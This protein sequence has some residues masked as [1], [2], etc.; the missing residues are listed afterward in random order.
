MV[1]TK[2]RIGTIGT[3][4]RVLVGL[5][6]LFLALWDGGL[7]FGLRW[8]DV[9]V[10]L[11]VLPGAMVGVGLAARRLGRGPLRFTGPVGLALNTAI[12]VALAA[13]EYTGA[14]A[15]LFYG[16]TLLVAAWRAQPG[17]EGLVL[18]NWIL[19]RDHQGGCP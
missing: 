11:V 9:A 6:L 5:G 4:S 8:Y 10:G 19:P 1:E 18:S 7:S 15:A 16:T 2:R 12:I 14:G 3:A 17:C 13:N